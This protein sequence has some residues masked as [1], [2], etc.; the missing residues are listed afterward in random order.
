MH[1]EH[2]RAARD[3]G[4]RTGSSPHRVGQLY[5][6]AGS[7]TPRSAAAFRARTMPGLS[8]ASSPS[9]AVGLQKLALEVDELHVQLQTRRVRCRGRPPPRRSR[10]RRSHGPGRPTRCACARS[11]YLQCRLGKHGARRRSRCRRPR[12]SRPGTNE[13]SFTTSRSGAPRSSSSSPR[14]SVA[15]NDSRRPT[16]LKRIAITVVRAKR[17]RKVRR[18]ALSRLRNGMRPRLL[19]GSGRRPTIRASPP[20]RAARWPVLMASTG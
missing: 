6:V 20:P 8:T 9:V 13:S 15:R 10:S 14:S 2:R 19:P 12:A 16:M 4:E 7:P 3:D 17:V 5:L 1:R 11:P 18:G